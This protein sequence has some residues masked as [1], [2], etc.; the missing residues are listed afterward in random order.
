MYTYCGIYLK[1]TR[2]IVQF[3][4]G[5]TSYAMH[6]HPLSVFLDAHRCVRKRTTVMHFI[7][8]FAQNIVMDRFQNHARNLFGK[9]GEYKNTFSC[10]CETP[11]SVENFAEKTCYAPPHPIYLIT[12]H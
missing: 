11:A 9:I 4:T 1:K 6:V 12:L 2:V 8:A 10:L 5:K 3:C 7:T